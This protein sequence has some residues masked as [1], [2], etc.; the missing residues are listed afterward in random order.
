MKPNQILPLGVSVLF[1]FLS[2][3]ANP[4]FRAGMAQFG[5]AMSQN[6]Q[7]KAN[8]PAGYYRPGYYQSFGQTADSANDHVLVPV[9]KPILTETKTI[10]TLNANR[11]DPNSLANPYGAGNPYKADGLM[12]PY[13]EYGSPF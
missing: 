4:R 13:S 5:A 7:R 12:N 10:G 11:Y 1:L 6:S 8:V 9:T 3:C 2:G